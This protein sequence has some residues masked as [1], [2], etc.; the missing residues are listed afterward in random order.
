MASEVLMTISK[1]E[2]ARVRLVS[3]Y[4]YQFDMQSKLVHAKRQGIKEVA[5]NLKTIGVP[6]KQIVRGTGLSPE[7]IAAL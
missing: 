5:R 3:E 6:I 2:V 7:E 1:D 4:K